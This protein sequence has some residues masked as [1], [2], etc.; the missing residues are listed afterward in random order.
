MS[1]EEHIQVSPLP[2]TIETG[3]VQAENGPRFIRIAFKTPQG[4][5]VFFMEPEGCEHVIKMLQMQLTQARGGIIVPTV[6]DK[7]FM[8]ELRKNGGHEK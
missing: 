1:G 8:E 2:M 5:S 6:N 4:V 7:R 3:W